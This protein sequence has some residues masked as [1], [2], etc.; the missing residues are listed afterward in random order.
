MRLLNLE[1]DNFRGIEHCNIV[2]PSDTRLLCMIGAGDS[3]K[4]TLLK[5]IEWVFYPA[6]NLSVCDNDFYCGNT[7]N[8]III[9]CTFTEF[10]EEFYSEDRFG[11]YLRKPGVPINEGVNDEPDV[12]MPLCLTIQLTVD[13][14]LEPVWNIVCN[15]KEPKIISHRERSKVVV[16]VVGSDCSKDMVWGR[17]SILQKYANAKS[18]LHKAYTEALRSVAQNADLSSLD[19]VSNR[20]NEVAQQYGVSFTGELHNKILFQNGTFTTTVGMYDGEAPLSQRGLGSQRLLSMGLNINSFDNGPIL[21]IDEVETGLEPYRIKS[22]INEFRTK[23]NETGQ[24]IITTHSPVVLSE[25]QIKELLI[26]QS[27]SGTTSMHR[28]ATEDDSLNKSLQGQAR[29][30]ADAFLC[31][32][33]IICEGK[34]EIGFI[35][36]LDNYISEKYGYRIAHKGV[37]VAL[38]GGENIFSYA[39]TFRRCGYEICLFMDSDK[40][41]DNEKKVELKNSFNIDTFDWESP[42]AIEE[43]IFKDIPMELVQPLIDIAVDSKSADGVANKLAANTIPFTKVDEDTIIVGELTEEQKKRIGTVAKHK[44]SEWYKR[45]DIGEAIGEI[46]FSKWESIEDTTCL[47]STVEKILKWVNYERTGTD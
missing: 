36:A 16:G 46:I 22:L 38:G 12:N 2:F 43:Q 20:F 30:N 42:N 33:L 19:E 35:R 39:E 17:Y 9:R 18:A 41:E 47:H 31:K 10:P 34:T 27:Q 28:I 40:P 5:A 1:I 32:R 23:H 14:S 15:R 6:W 29:L 13:D 7:N 25:C 45:I 37:G 44:R 26:I 11:F 3:T 24:I 8:P 4:T 21:I